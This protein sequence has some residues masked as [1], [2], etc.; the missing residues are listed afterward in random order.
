MPEI[1]YDSGIKNKINNYMVCLILGSTGLVGS[2]LIK[3]VSKHSKISRIITLVRNDSGNSSSSSKIEENIVDF[4]IPDYEAFFEGVD[5]VFCCLGTTLKQAG[6]R[7]AAHAIDFDLV[8]KLA[9]M[10]KKH[11]VDHFIV[12]SSMGADTRSANFYLNTKG[13][14]E[15]K[16]KELNFNHFSSVRPSLLLGERKASRINEKFGEIA[17]NLFGFL[18]KGKL[19]KYKA[20]KA[21][22]VAGAMLQIALF[23]CEKEFYESNELKDL[24]NQFS[25]SI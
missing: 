22:D 9:K 7:K 19:A 11:S 8:L 23:P 5:V 4:N 18:L 1:F 24:A 16:I 13:K 25:S 17:L 21:E 2:E 12:V 15:N 6:S 14:M 3:I 20:I 10:A